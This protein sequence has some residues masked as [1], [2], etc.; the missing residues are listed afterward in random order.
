MEIIH[1]SGVQSYMSMIF[2]FSVFV[3]W[4]SQ[5]SRC[6]MTRRHQL[7]RRRNSNK[8]V[9]PRC[10]ISHNII[11]NEDKKCQ[12]VDGLCK[13]NCFM[14]SASAHKWLANDFNWKI[15]TESGVSLWLTSQNCGCRK[16]F[17]LIFTLNHFPPIFGCRLAEDK[18]LTPAL[19][20]TF[21]SSWVSI[22]VLQ[23]VY[24]NM[25]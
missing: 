6:A 16:M 19:H 4:E 23:A 9:V 1:L 20:T 12:T 5:Y 2:V 11:E 21:E 24:G 14:S 17:K 15:A 18:T 25:H 10:T 22:D 3:E 13:T 8:R 7:R